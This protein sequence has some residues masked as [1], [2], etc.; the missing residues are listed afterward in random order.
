MSHKI[1]SILVT[2]G[3]VRME[4]LAHMLELKTDRELRSKGG[5]RGIIDIAA[6]EILAE[7]GK[8]LIVGMGNPSG[9]WLTDDVK[10]IRKIKARWVRWLEPIKV[11]RVDYLERCVRTMEKKQEEKEA[12]NQL[13]LL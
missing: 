9:V 12:A 7:Q 13:V 2:Q 3:T 10:Q 5:D 11:H 6:D 8:A 4:T 1:Y